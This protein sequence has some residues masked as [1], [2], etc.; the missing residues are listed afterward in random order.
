[1]IECRNRAMKW[2]RPP[3]REARRDIDGKRYVDEHPIGA[4]ERSCDDKGDRERMARL[5][6]VDTTGFVMHAAANIH[7]TM[8]HNELLY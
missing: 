4:M 8:C 3:T 7:P 6:D 1:M 5:Q 2:E